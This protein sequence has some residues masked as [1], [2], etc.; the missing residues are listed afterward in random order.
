MRYV[1]FVACLVGAVLAF[2][3]FHAG[4]PTF[5]LCIF[6][7]LLALSMLGV[8]DLVQAR[9]G[10]LRNYPVLGHLRYILEFIRPE[11]RQYFFESDTDGV[12]YNR[13]ERALVY[14]RAKGQLDY[15]PFGTE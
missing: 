2:P 13:S 1:F 15:R 11:L 8:W 5:F 3:A 12:P 7:G 6:V 10:V 4:H 9:H 14:Q